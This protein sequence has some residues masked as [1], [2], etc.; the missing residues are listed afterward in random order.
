MPTGSWRRAL[1]DRGARSA[2]TKPKPRRI[3][4][5]SASRSTIIVDVDIREWWAL[6]AWVATAPPKPPDRAPPVPPVFDGN[7]L[8]A[9]VVDVVLDVDFGFV[10]EVVD[11]GF[12]TGARPP[13]RFRLRLATLWTVVAVRLLAA[14]RVLAP[15]VDTSFTTTDPTRPIASAVTAIVARRRRRPPVEHQAAETRMDQLPPVTLRND[16]RPIA[17]IPTPSAANPATSERSPPPVNGR[18]E[19]VIAVVVDV[20]PGAWTVDDVE[21]F[22]VDVE[23]CSWTVE[24]VDAPSVE[25]DIPIVVEVDELVEVLVVVETLVEDRGTVVVVVVVRAVLDVLGTV[26][27]EDSVLVEV[28]AIVVEVVAQFDS[29]WLAS[30]CPC[31]CPSK[32]Q[33]SSASTVCVPDPT[34]IE[35]TSV[36]DGPS[37]VKS[38]WATSTPSIITDSCDVAVTSGKLS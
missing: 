5:P 26:V 17:S 33:W 14:G 36:A 6:T 37:K 27:V 11:V 16:A 1:V 22:V 28:L 13:F 18:F 20:E 4:G 35:M 23:P 30:A 24:L 3:S 15:A 38:C 2:K 34:E 19:G 8:R 10:V 31:G 21:G 12:K 7:V 25:V 32:D 29:S 9:T